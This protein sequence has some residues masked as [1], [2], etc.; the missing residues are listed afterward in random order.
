MNS[1]SPF[2]HHKMDNLPNETHGRAQPSPA[3]SW[4]AHCLPGSQ[5]NAAFFLKGQTP[6]LQRTLT[7]QDDN[8]PPCRQDGETVLKLVEWREEAPYG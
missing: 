7:P 3:D 8:A 5:K 1:L 4:Q 6:G 2:I